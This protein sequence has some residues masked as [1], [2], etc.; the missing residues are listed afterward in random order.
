MI[1]TQQK[2]NRRKY[3]EKLKLLGN[4]D[5]NTRVFKVKY[6]KTGKNYVLKEVEAPSHEKLNEYKEEVVQVSRE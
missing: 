6:I 1:Q 4:G 5:K 2:M 3:F